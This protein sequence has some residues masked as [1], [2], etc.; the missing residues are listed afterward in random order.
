MER[1]GLLTGRV[2]TLGDSVAVGR[3]MQLVALLVS[4]LTM[5]RAGIQSFGYWKSGGLQQCG[6]SVAYSLS[7]D[8]FRLGVAWP[9]LDLAL[10]FFVFVRLATLPWIPAS[11]A[12]EQPQRLQSS[13]PLSFHD[14]RLNIALMSAAVALVAVAN[15]LAFTL[16]GNDS[17]STT[18][19]KEHIYWQ[20][21]L[22][23]WL[24]IA[25]SFARNSLMASKHVFHGRFNK[26]LAAAL[27][28][29]LSICTAE[30]FY[31]LFTSGH[32][33]EA[34]GQTL[35]SRFVIASAAI[36]LAA[37]ITPLC[38]H[39]QGFFL[40]QGPR[41]E[42]SSEMVTETSQIEVGPQVNALEYVTPLTRMRSNQ[43]PMVTSPEQSQ[44]A[45]GQL[46]FSWVTPVLRMGTKVVINSSDLYHLHS[47]DRPL[48]I[49]R[50][51]VSCRKPGRTLLRALGLTFAP[52][53]VWQ[54]VLALLNALLSFANPFFMSRI[55]R[56]IRMYNRDYPYNSK[57]L[58]YLDAIGLL[59][60]TLLH[61]ISSNQV[62]WIGRKVS[63]RLQS[64]LVAE[65]SSKAL[66]R[67][68]KSSAPTK[69]K[70]NEDESQ[71]TTA[72]SDGR[73]VN[74]LTSDLENIGHI[75][76]YIDH[77]CTLP[78][79]FCIG[80]WFLYN[81][82]GMSAIIG[83][84]MIAIYYPLTK[85]SMKIIMKYQRRYL[86][87]IDERVSM[88]TE[89]F[90]GIRAVKLFGWQERF[91]AKVQAKRKEE[92]R[93]WWA[94]TFFQLPISF[95]RS[96]S[97]SLILVTILAIYSLFYGHELTADVVFPAMTVFSI[98]SATFNGIPGIFR[99]MTH[100]Y[101]SLSRIESFMVQSQIQ[102]LE[103][104]VDLN[105][106]IQSG[107]IGFV[108][109]S[110]EWDCC[111]DEEA[112]NGG[113]KS[114]LSPPANKSASRSSLSNSL[115]SSESEQ[116]P[117][118]SS[119][120]SATYDSTSSGV[121]DFDQVPTPVT[122]VESSN[123][124][125][126]SSKG[127]MQFKLT[128]ITLQFPIGGLSLV[129]GPTGSG[130][131][132]LL[133]ALIGEMTLTQGRVILPTADPRIL[134][135][136]LQNSRYRE[137]IELASQGPV[138]TDVAYVSQEAWLRNAS[139]RE[140]IL[141]GEPYDA[142]RYEEVL[143]MCALKPD[144]RLLAAGDRTEIGER[145]ITLSGGQKQRMALARA[146]YSHRR[147]LLIDDCLSAVDAHTAKHILNECLVSQTKLM[148]GRTRVLVT[149]HVSLCLPHS[150]FVAVMQSG[151]VA[152]SGTPEKL[153]Q[154]GYFTDELKSLEGNHNAEEKEHDAH[155]VNDMTSEDTY[156]AQRAES[157]DLNDGALVEDEEREQGYVRP[158]VWIDY[159]LMCGKWKFWTA[160]IAFVFI[161]RGASISQDYWMRIWMGDANSGQ[162]AKHNV[163]Y[164][165]GIYVLLGVGAMVLRMSTSLVEQYGGICAAQKY[166]EQ[167]LKRLINA[168]PRFFDCTPIGRVVSRFSRDM[169]TID[170]PILD[171]ITAL[172]YQA[173]HVAT[174]FTIISMVTPPFAAIAITMTVAYVMLGIYYLNAT[175][176]LKRLD[177]IS[178]SPLLSLFSELITGVESIRAFGAQNQY[179]MEAMS[180][181]D[182]H[183]RPFYMLWA[184]NRWL[185]TR[186]EF[187]GCIVSFSTTVL[188]ISSLDRIDAGLAGFVL[189]YA[190]SFSDSM[191]WFIRNYSDCEISMNS[192]ERVNQYLA[193]EQEAAPPAEKYLASSWPSSGRVEISD[194]T[195]EYVPG[196]PVLHN[197][198]LSIKHGEKIGVV[199]RTGAGKSTLSL[200][201]LRFLEAAHGSIVIDGV[202]I[203]T[204]ALDD[205]RRRITIIPQDPVLF[206]G[207]IRFNLD[208]FD[209]Y[210][211]EIIWDALKRAH[212]VSE[213]FDSSSSE[214]IECSSVDGAA[215]GDE[216]QSVFTSLDAEIKENG[217]NLS[218]GQRQLVAIARALV[219]RSRLVILDEATAS[220]DFELDSRIQRTIRG[221]EFADSSLLCIAHRLRTIIDY[222][223][224]LVLDKG[225]VAEFDTPWNLLHKP[226]GLFR[227]M[228]KPLSEW[229]L[230][231]KRW[232]SQRRTK[233]YLKAVL[234]CSISSILLFIQPLR[235]SIGTLYFQIMITTAMAHGGTTVGANLE[236]Q[237]QQILIGIIVSAYI[238]IIEG[239]VH[240]LGKNSSINFELAAKITNGTALAIFCFCVASAYTYTPRLILPLKINTTSAYLAFTRYQQTRKF[241]VRPL[242]GFVYAQ[243]IGAAIST[244]VNIFVF[245][246][247]AS[248][249]LMGSYRDLLKE[250]TECC[251]YFE[252][253]V[254]ELGKENR[255]GSDVA[256][257]LRRRVR[258]AAERFGHIVGGSRYE[259]SI[260]RFSQIDY[261]YVF[262]D[263][264]RL[265]SSFITMCLPFEIDDSF[266]YQLEDP[267]AQIKHGSMTTIN[268]SMVSL[269]SF[270]SENPHMARNPRHQLEGR[271]LAEIAETHRHAE[272]R[273]QGMQ[274][275][276]APIKAQVELHRKILEI[277]LNRTK[278]MVH[279]SGSKTLLDLVTRSLKSV[280]K[281]R[282]REQLPG[283]SDFVASTEDE[284]NLE[285]YPESMMFAA[286]DRQELHD[287]LERMSLEQLAEVVDQHIEIFEQTETEC[288]EM[289]APYRVTDD[290]HTHEKQVVMLSFIGAMREN[291]ICMS[292]MLRTL[293][294]I[295]VKRPEYAQIWFPKLNWSWLY[296][297]RIDEEEEDNQDDPVNDNWDLENAFG[298][299]ANRDV[300]NAPLDSEHKSERSMSMLS[301]ANDRHGDSGSD[302]GMA[303]DQSELPDG[304][305]PQRLI[306]QHTT[307]MGALYQMKDSRYAR[308]AR[309]AL[310]W[311]K[312]PKTQ[313]AFKFTI[314]MMVWAIWSFISV[315]SRFF[316]VNNGSWGM[317]CIAT[318][319]GVTI[320]ST[321]NA[322]FSRVFG[323]SVS[324]AWAIVAWQASNYGR[325]PYLPCF[326]CIVYFVI[327]FYVGFFVPKWASI[328]PVMVISF[329][330]VLF[331]AYTEGDAARGTSL[332]WK[333]A[334][335]NAVAIL[336]TFVVSGIFM[337][338]KARTALRKR[339]AELLRL[340]SLVVQG[341]NH[342]HVARAE[343]PTVHYNELCRVRD[344]IFQSRI[345]ISKCRNL[346]PSAVRE[347]SVHEKF[348]LEAHCLLIDTLE[349]Q[350]E[351]LLYSF[352]THKTH[353]SE[354][355]S[356]MIRLALGMREDIIGSKVIFNN[357][358]SSA[359][360]AKRR[361]PAYLP[362]I[363]TARQQ[364]IREMHPM[365]D[366]KYTRSFDITY[367]SRWKV[368]IWHLIA[369][370][371]DLCTA[372]RAIVGAETDRW[373]EE[374]G[375]MLDSLE[376][377]PPLETPP[378]MGSTSHNA[379]NSG[380]IKGQW[381]A[382]LPKYAPNNSAY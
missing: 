225:R 164:W 147:I 65:M 239:I 211:D 184:A 213:N 192:V 33:H 89:V 137:V 29:Q 142:E 302:N 153:Q 185:C 327:S 66:R 174:V 350:L 264:S 180:R 235:R 106:T 364:F 379:G 268:R 74:L 169:S 113:P 215:A 197:L 344:S 218:L 40:P 306:R 363:G 307:D 282:K 140:N 194:L 299:D 76:S 226:D 116:T 109:A 49:W 96:I 20:A 244:V 206:N 315:S 135:A 338:Y 139:I 258:K 94:M 81:L 271:S 136:Q 349:F 312:R 50:R 58:I 189:M 210:P 228:Y 22:A 31:A 322:G 119:Q 130:K 79:E 24:V 371:K 88:L 14:N 91:F 300:I 230:Q 124:K 86:R 375:F 247:T 216:A 154:I 39:R 207:T 370:Q 75:A 331:I 3:G 359:L 317:T 290:S 296:R 41:Q 68:S 56:S 47:S 269:Q 280:Y 366:D 83:L 179:T 275:A 172:I 188:I 195:I 253:S 72:G 161:N 200:A 183:N 288:I 266:Y 308:I 242:P 367:L 325:H 193:L 159:M 60:S 133:S 121:D 354:V 214:S 138:M 284:V 167:L 10:A 362:D 158:Q 69:K 254:A 52:Q 291:A 165:L 376:M 336:F 355:L 105:A 294:K 44:S 54:V 112:G 101:V 365:L 346:I 63:M 353:K 293:H 289:L 356:R 35:H 115:E 249:N 320:G 64:L 311:A 205:L 25:C 107:E 256:A 43:I 231:F 233:D 203:S 196:T 283:L 221:P 201:F 163:I 229:T 134:D 132:S 171:F 352:F 150:Q 55:L 377:A 272:R 357:I 257:Q 332:G 328:A 286:D 1:Q 37:T 323:S 152:V 309:A 204:I 342:M 156:Y 70:E 128:D 262:L 236:V 126:A 177:S 237:I 148:Q 267:S 45:I 117:L 202:D 84:C 34:I 335:V 305:G 12:G 36:G 104:R 199:G 178:M 125:P 347:P 30:G 232:L 123:G 87:L 103:E 160:V 32:L 297:G 223:R 240:G 224:V 90:Y 57:R 292:S 53:L 19:H 278:V 374:V 273:K 144:L 146:V 7:S 59:L 212:L 92:I 170:D 298:T 95:V 316:Y 340:N 369:T 187:S 368:G 118:I 285:E 217:Q 15:S 261:H 175:R 182:I 155:S 191:L 330:S 2:R 238:L 166:H 46:L 13:L 62:L 321:F 345:L 281:Y 295:N 77:I 114:P 102:N 250:L 48:A 122:C 248:H 78:I 274:Q 28:V 82:L 108:N 220:V 319:F 361:L 176:E 279:V 73:V 334:A 208:P 151:R 80:S 51:Y 301:L 348:Q 245:P 358:L 209:E 222:D 67:R 259:T 93:A 71:D 380:S 198:S 277:L 360:L 173:M 287:Q 270:S 27:V 314:T 310:D 381:F 17:S 110:F 265:A 351:W 181:A 16:L 263:S 97:T 8:C 318:V 168:V 234:C 61:S 143:R 100:C 38:A 111:A 326:C 255:R 162:A 260:D 337:P 276:I 9:M 4:G 304:S 131:S 99:W 219:R 120:Q 21:T 149:H 85:F 190:T 129:V 251:V 246:R 324:G 186:I 252:S 5:Y 18:Q 339:L 157:G 341:I 378:V 23:F 313:Y 227:Q 145:G 141:F 343:F 303:P 26:E 42:S 329:S 382:R 98:V 373:P 333:H 241:D 11:S 127:T 6:S 243:L 372:V